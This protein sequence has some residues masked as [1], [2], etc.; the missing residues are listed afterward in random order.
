MSSIKSQ[1]PP[2]KQYIFDY[3]GRVDESIYIIDI[4][5]GTKSKLEQQ[6]VTNQ[7]YTLKYET[8]GADFPGKEAFVSKMP[9]CFI[10][11]GLK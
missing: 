11:Q 4:T 3:L 7:I 5:A 6:N 8:E 1:L 2:P 10:V 9:T